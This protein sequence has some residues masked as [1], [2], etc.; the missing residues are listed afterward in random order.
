MRRL[1]RYCESLERSEP[2]TNFPTRPVDRR[3]IHLSPLFLRPARLVQA[4][5]CQVGFL[6]HVDG[7]EFFGS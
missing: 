6:H 4:Q 2:D 5:F 3:L 7:A 1:L